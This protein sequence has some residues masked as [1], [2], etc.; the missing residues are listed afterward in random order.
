[1]LRAAG[2][3]GGEEPRGHRAGSRAA[4]A[5]VAP[6]RGGGRLAGCVERHQQGEVGIY[7]RCVEVVGRGGRRPAETLQRARMDREAVDEPEGETGRR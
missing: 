5:M 7:N 1:M 4:E 2:R 6:A 3:L